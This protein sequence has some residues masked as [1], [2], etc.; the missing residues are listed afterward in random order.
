MAVVDSLDLYTQ[1]LHESAK[2]RPYEMPALLTI[3][4]FFRM[5]GPHL[6]SLVECRIDTQRLRAL[7]HLVDSY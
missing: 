6:S 4:H 7:L 2:V 1:R 5:L 3:I